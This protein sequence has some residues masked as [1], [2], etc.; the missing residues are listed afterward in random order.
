MADGLLSKLLSLSQTPLFHIP[1]NILQV[2]Q[3]ISLSNLDKCYVKAFCRMCASDNIIHLAPFSSGMCY[4]R[5]PHVR[6]VSW[7]KLNEPAAI[8]DAVN[9][10][11][12]MYS[13]HVRLANQFQQK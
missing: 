9:I 2:L 4:F 1:T 12:A 5:K 8:Q 11:S 7:E 13:Q 6:R 10:M 3:T